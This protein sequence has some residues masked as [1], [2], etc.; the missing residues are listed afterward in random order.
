MKLIV[1]FTLLSILVACSY[2]QPRSPIKQR[3][4]TT[5]VE[6]NKELLLKETLLIEQY[7]TTQSNLAYNKSPSGLW[8]AASDINIFTYKK[9]TQIDF[10]YKVL[11]LNNKLVYDRNTI[12][13]QTYFVDEQPI[14]YG[15]KEALSL[16]KEG[17]SG[18]FLLP[19]ILAYGVLGDQNKIDSNTPLVIQLKITNIETIN[20]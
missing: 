17:A 1:Y 15:L 10:E 14:M 8:Y 20:K 7:I 12:G 4:E 2:P 13:K 5:S 19:S 16:L 3:V 11:D 9:G 18:T 6:K